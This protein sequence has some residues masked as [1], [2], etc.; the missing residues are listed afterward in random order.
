M[1]AARQRQGVELDRRRRSRWPRHSRDRSSSRPSDTSIIAV[2][3]G[4]SAAPAV[5]QRHRPAVDDRPAA[6]S[7]SGSSRNC[8]RPAALNRRASRPATAGRPACRRLRDGVRS[9]ARPIAVR[10][11][12]RGAPAR[13]GDGVAADQR[14][15]DSSRRPPR[16][17]RGRPRPS[18]R[19]RW[20][21]TARPRAG[22]A[23]LAARSRQVDRDQL[24]ADA[25]PAGRPG[26]KCTP[27]A[28]L[29]WVRTSP[30]SSAA[31]SASPRAAGSVAMRRS[32]A[33]TSRSFM[34]AGAP[35]LPWR[36]RRAGR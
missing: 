36:W 30:S 5:E 29:S 34:P 6:R 7:P 11:S 2:A 32:R 1:K 28:M 4:A 22:V 3:C 16:S 17:R 25:M 9:P 23:P 24:P 20:S 33:I 10:P 14:Q 31:S 35:R 12:T 21:A 15:A 26:R 19:R 13:Q 8:A 27:S 18:R